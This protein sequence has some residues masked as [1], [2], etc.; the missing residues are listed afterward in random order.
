MN[1][2]KVTDLEVIQKFEA[3]AKG[4]ET[5]LDNLDKNIREVKKTTLLDNKSLGWLEFL[6]SSRVQLKKVLQ[7][8]NK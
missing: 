5:M 2:K 7:N 1:W 4:L 6:E 8:R 3:T